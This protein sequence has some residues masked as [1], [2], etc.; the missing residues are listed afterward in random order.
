M[1]NLYARLSAIDPEVHLVIMNNFSEMEKVSKRSLPHCKTSSD[2]SLL[3]LI[4]FT[5]S[6]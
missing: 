1:V 6:L 3:S 4:N 2:Y 5:V